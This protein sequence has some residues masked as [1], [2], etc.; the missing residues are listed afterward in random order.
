MDA[1][2]ERVI[3]DVP[4]PPVHSAP[5]KPAITTNVVVTP[6]VV[7]V[8]PPTVKDVPVD[9]PLH[10]P[11][12]F[13]TVSTAERGARVIVDN[14]QIGVTPLVK[15]GVK[16]GAAHR[17]EVRR[18][19]LLLLAQTV[20]LDD[21]KV[22]VIVAP[23]SAPVVAAPP[24]SVAPQVATTPKVKTA[25]VTSD[26]T[27]AAGAGVVARCNACHATRNVGA[28]SARRYT[29][30]QWERFFASGQHD[31]YEGL[32]LSAGDLMNARAFLRSRA[33]DAAENQGAGIQEQ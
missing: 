33:A 13:I 30:T 29:Q 26:G 21:G 11:M 2:P 8:A 4:K 20:Q 25:R 32:S 14:V 18:D 19:A 23:E 28:V 31:R 7:E 17:V 5:S 3:R 22:Q 27:V 24:P 16:A 15:Y 6:P 9:A 1:K 10:I 12:A